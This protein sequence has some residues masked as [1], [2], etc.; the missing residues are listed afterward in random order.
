MD[1]DSHHLDNGWADVDGVS[2]FDWSFG[3]SLRNVQEYFDCTN[4]HTPIDNIW[5]A[6]PVRNGT[7]W[8]WKCSRWSEF[9]DFARDRDLPR[10]EHCPNTGQGWSPTF[11]TS[12]YQRFDR[13]KTPVWSMG[14]WCS[15]YCCGR[16]MGNAERILQ[17]SKGEPGPSCWHRV[18]WFPRRYISSML[19]V[20]ERWRNWHTIPSNAP[21]HR[22][23][24][25]VDFARSD[26]VVPE[27][28]SSSSHGWWSVFERSC[29][30]RSVEKSGRC[31]VRY[32]EEMSHSRR[33]TSFEGRCWYTP[34]VRHWSRRPTRHLARPARAKGGVSVV[35]LACCCFSLMRK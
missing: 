28:G 10:R 17:M 23:A 11:D 8:N 5:S 2:V 20:E 15:P 31:V 3:R 7:E 27:G 22:R 34:P 1:F 30:W 16:A 25:S 6:C 13:P 29:R 12:Q 21:S 33:L 9:D 14:R 18:V 19:I 35:R 4:L 26:G 24:R 32:I